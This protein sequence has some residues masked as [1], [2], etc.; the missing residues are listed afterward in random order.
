MQGHEKGKQDQK[1]KQTA[2]ETT[3]NPGQR[4]ASHEQTIHELGSR[5][6]AITTKYMNKNQPKIPLIE[7]TPH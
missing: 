7:R 2:N 5:K 4:Q 6:E 3:R 1:T